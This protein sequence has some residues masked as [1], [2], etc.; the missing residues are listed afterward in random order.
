MDEISIIVISIDL[1]LVA[2]LILIVDDEH[3]VAQDAWD[4][5]G[6]GAGL[7]CPFFRFLG[8]TGNA[9][10]DQPGVTFQSFSYTCC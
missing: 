4:D 2:I 10:D 7:T 1:K 6:E 9:S 5:L 3:S 8:F